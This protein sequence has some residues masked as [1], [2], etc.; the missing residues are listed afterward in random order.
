[1]TFFEDIRVAVPLTEE[2]HDALWRSALVYAAD[3]EDEEVKNALIALGSLWSMPW[4]MYDHRR[5]AE[6]MENAILYSPWFNYYEKL[7]L[8]HIHRKACAVLV[9]ARHMDLTRGDAE[10]IQTLASDFDNR[11]VPTQ[12][13]EVRR[14]LNWHGHCNNFLSEMHM[15]FGYGGETSIARNIKELLELVDK[16]EI[17]GEALTKELVR[18]RLEEQQFLE[19]YD[20]G[21]KYKASTVRWNILEGRQ[22]TEWGHDAMRWLRYPESSPEYIDNVILKINEE[23][24]ELAAEAAKRARCAAEKAAQSISAILAEVDAV[25]KTDASA[26]AKAAADATPEARALAEAL[27]NFEATPE[28]QAAAAAAAAAREADEISIER[29]ALTMNGESSDDDDYES[30]SVR[31]AKESLR[32]RR[33]ALH[34]INDYTRFQRVP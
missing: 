11:K 30:I 5:A 10:W 12:A 2:I 3:S 29:R 34:V 22:L 7:S 18:F 1:M 9:V 20:D 28:A 8:W 31:Y 23:E 16:K 13:D 14:R 21:A 6:S 15:G 17:E 4:Q 19:S 27:A 24:A 33:S 32:K 25:R 26:A